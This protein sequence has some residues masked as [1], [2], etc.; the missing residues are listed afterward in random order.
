MELLAILFIVLGTMM[1]VAAVIRSF[2]ASRAHRQRYLS[3]FALYVV[4]VW[5][6]NTTRLVTSY[7][8]FNTTFISPWIQAVST[9]TEAA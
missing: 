2:A 3:Y 1:G 9:L 5:A 6:G 4:L 8:A 7:L